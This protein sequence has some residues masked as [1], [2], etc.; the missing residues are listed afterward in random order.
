M[1]HRHAPQVSPQHSTTHASEA[2]APR[3]WLI[4]LALSGLACAVLWAVTSWGP[5]SPIVSGDGYYVYLTA[6]SIAFDGDLDLSNQY[7]SL[8]DRWG[9]GRW[10][11]D[12]GTRFPPREIFPSALM[13]LGLWLGRLM[14][15]PQGLDPLFACTPIS[16]LLGLTYALSV[17]LEARA[18]T[19]RNPSAEQEAP[20]AMSVP[21]TPSVTAE[22]LAIVA[23]VLLATPLPFYSAVQPAYSHAA[24]AF[25][26]TLLVLAICGWRRHPQ[27]SRSELYLALAMTLCVLTRLQNLL[28]IA[29]PLTVLV[30]DA[31]AEH[32]RAAARAAAAMLLGGALGLAPQGA[33]ALMHPGSATGPVRWGLDFFDLYD[34]PR[35]L[36]TVLMGTNGLLVH[37]PVVV[38]ALL[39]LLS[40]AIPAAS[41]KER[42]EQRSAAIASLA[43]VVVFVV[44]M[45]LVRDPDGG[46]SFGA[47]RL[48][49]LT[50]IWILG[51]SLALDRLRVSR[52]VGGRLAARSD[53][54]RTSDIPAPP[55]HA[56]DHDATTVRQH[57][58]DRRSDREWDVSTAARSVR[59]TVFFAAL[60]VLAAVN[61]MQ[62]AAQ[63]AGPASRA[64][65]AAPVSA[66]HSQR[67]AP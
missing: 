61:L 66:T 58:E 63:R 36:A 3:G 31:R 51:I 21:V 48:C 43:T 26:C 30:L 35:D 56:H 47:R 33:L 13:A 14:R 23:S 62:V 12:D 27:Q 50:P 25:V 7:H 24:D 10:P 29:W 49:G 55:P 19:D 1:W 46:A 15:A 64:D 38:L 59:E 8:G 2:R 4:A 44:L 37:S 41:S 39:G 60:L 54:G 11:A 45:A 34:L 40:A 28:W 32:R 67:A 6:R 65:A 16:A 22:Q 18:A 42:D 57:T 17:R 52:R 9:L 5:R 20:L 53:V